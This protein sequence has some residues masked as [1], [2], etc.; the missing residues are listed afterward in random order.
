MLGH[1]IMTCTHNYG[2]CNNC[3]EERRLRARL[4]TVQATHPNY[5]RVQTLH[6]RLVDN[7]RAIR[8][9]ERRIRN[10]ERARERARRRYEQRLAILGQF[11]VS[12]S[13]SEP[14]ISDYEENSEDERPQPLQ[15]R[16]EL[17]KTEY[18]EECAICYE[19]TNGMTI[20][21]HRLC[22]SCEPKVDKCPLCR[23]SLMRIIRHPVI[24]D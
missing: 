6:Q 18:T 7:H 3:V 14:D 23:E 11:Y 20:C 21:L 24:I 9:N 4:P 8:D 2:R 17:Y 16:K 13:D 22:D 1:S 19:A 5:H 12:D 15:V 10:D